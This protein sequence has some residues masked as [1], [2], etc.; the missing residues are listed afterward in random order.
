MTPSFVWSTWNLSVLIDSSLSFV[1]TVRSESKQFHSMVEIDSESYQFSTT[2]TTI[3]LSQATVIFPTWI[4]AAVSPVLLWF[5]LC[6]HILVEELVIC[7]PPLLKTPWTVGPCLSLLCWKFFQKVTLTVLK[8]KSFK[9]QKGFSHHSSS[10]TCLLPLS[11]VLLHF[12][13][14]GLLAVSQHTKYKPALGT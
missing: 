7:V 10:Q 6:A 12:S 3:S 14:P 9:V 5:C 13:H 2:Y 11:P 4:A 1:A 8:P